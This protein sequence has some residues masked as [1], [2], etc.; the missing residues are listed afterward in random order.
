MLALLFEYDK[1]QGWIGR[2]MHDHPGLF[3]RLGFQVIRT[4]PGAIAAYG[5]G[6][7]GPPPLREQ[8]APDWEMVAATLALALEHGAGDTRKTALGFYDQARGRQAA[9]AGR[10]VASEAELN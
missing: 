1:E 4:R 10:P 5:A 8:G 7:G 9:L 2:L 6:Y 3:G